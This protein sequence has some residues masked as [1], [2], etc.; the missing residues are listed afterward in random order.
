MRE[1]ETGATRDTD[2]GKL[3]Y[4]GFLHPKVLQCF[5]TFMNK[6]RVQADGKLRAS[7]NWQKGIPKDAYM[8]SMFRHFMEVWTLHRGCATGAPHEAL[9][10]LMFNV[11]GYLFEA[12]KAEGAT[13][14]D[15][16]V[17]S[18]ET[19]PA[20]G[21][22]SAPTPP[23]PVGGLSARDKVELYQLI[24][25]M[26]DMCRFQDQRRT[27][28]LGQGQSK[29]TCPPLRPPAPSATLSRGCGP[30]RGPKGI[31]TGVARLASTRGSATPGKA[32][33]PRRL[34]RKRKSC[35]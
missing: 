7:D 14:R 2:E 19:P 32:S 24:Q 15:K 20:I 35:V 31:P 17:V 9:C 33:S 1:F 6:N 22:G 4:E 11:M 23:A 25:H 21:V 18:H 34:T 3:D 10:A 13:G 29:D 28:D 16:D 26:Q 12:L 27:S 8:K 30:A 5:A